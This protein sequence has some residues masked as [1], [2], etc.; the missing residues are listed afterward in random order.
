MGVSG[1]DLSSLGLRIQS[2]S[3]E[4]MMPRVMVATPI[5]HDH[6]PS[7]FMM[8]LHSLKYPHDRIVLTRQDSPFLADMRNMA[9]QQCLDG[10]FD[11]LVMIDS[12]MVFPSDALNRLVAHQKPVVSGHC[13]RRRRPFDPTTAIRDDLGRLSL[14]RLRGRG[15]FP[16]DAVG[17]AFLYVDRHVLVDIPKPWFEVGRVGEDYDFCEKATKA[18]YQIYVDLDLRIGHI[19]Q[20][21]IWP[22][23]DGGFEVQMK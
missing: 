14:V 4:R 12:D 3:Q 2:L 1:V 18:G 20:A 22:G 23:D 6:T 16:V 7:D 13:L 21:V 9:A 8:A 15:L 10:G 5:N 11:G 17:A 19:T